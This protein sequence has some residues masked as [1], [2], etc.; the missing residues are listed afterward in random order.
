MEKYV[1][2]HSF[3]HELWAKCYS[4][5]NM[6]VRFDEDLLSIVELHEFIF[7]KRKR[8]KKYAKTYIHLC[9]RSRENVVVHDHP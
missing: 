6:C 7:I 4:A 1:H 8:L 3:I 2:L 9:G 5:S